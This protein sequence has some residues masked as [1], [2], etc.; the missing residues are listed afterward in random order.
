MAIHSPAMLIAGL[1]LLAVGA[2]LWRWSAR[3]SI[4]L[5]G[6]ALGTAFAA[7]KSRTLPSVPEG[8]RPHLDKVS[9]ETT[10]MGRAKAVGGSVVRHFL[11]KVAGWASMASIFAGVVLV[12][13]SV[14]WK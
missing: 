9:A 1:V 6:A 11:A 10:N 5:R 12:A 7:A 2:M 8:L 13:L 3:Y 4:D 14:L